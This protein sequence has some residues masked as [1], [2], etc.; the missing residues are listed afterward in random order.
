PDVRE[1]QRAQQERSWQVLARVFA[2]SLMRFICVQCQNNWTATVYSGPS[3]PEL[4]VFAP[5]YGSF[6]TAH[7][8]EP[9]AFYLDQAR[10][11][12][13]TSAFTAAIAMYRGALE[14]LL[15]HQKV[16][17]GSLAEQLKTV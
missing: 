9:V 2:P 17:G 15:I 3:G 13:S 10:R 16:K 8:P 5:G 11:C 14:Q 1:I 7:T 4:A 6:R 12:E